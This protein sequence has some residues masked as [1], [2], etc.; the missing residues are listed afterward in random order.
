MGSIVG[1]SQ[2]GG[3]TRRPPRCDAVAN[4]LLLLSM[5]FA[6]HNKLGGL[7][8]CLDLDSRGFVAGG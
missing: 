8:A 3:K 1:A 2:C 7:V 4:A 6:V 5:M